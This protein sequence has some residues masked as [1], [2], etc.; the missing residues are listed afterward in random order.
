M[1][2]GGNTIGGCSAAPPGVSRR[3]RCL[4]RRCRTARG[5]R[6]QPDDRGERR[7]GPYTF[8][9]TSGALPAGLTLTAAG[10]CRDADHRRHLPRS[11]LPRRTRTAVPRASPIRSPSRPRRSARADSAVVRRRRCRHATSGVIQQ[12]DE[13]GSGGVPVA[14]RWRR[15]SHRRARRRRRRAPTPTV[16]PPRRVV[17]TAAPALPGRCPFEARDGRS[18]SPRS[19]SRSTGPTRRGPARSRRARLVPVRD[20]GNRRP[21]AAGVG[22]LVLLVSG[23]APPMSAPRRRPS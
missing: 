7:A 12:S 23:P 15:R 3:S 22:V 21:D 4:R 8:A 14:S 2:T 10:C 1:P 5:R 6:L 17:I 19:P 11:P 9:V 18:A 20:R 13:A 16:V